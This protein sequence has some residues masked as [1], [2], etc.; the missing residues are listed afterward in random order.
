MSGTRF[1]ILLLG[2]GVA[3]GIVFYTLPPLFFFPLEP[4]SRR[5]VVV[6]VPKGSSTSEIASL[7]VRAG[8]IRSAFG[9][10]ALVAV[11]GS[12]GRLQAGE[13]ELSPSLTPWEIIRRLERGQVVRRSFT[14]PEG[15][16]AADVARRLARLGYGREED[17]LR[18]FSDLSLLNELLP[19]SGHPGAR[20]VRV[21]LEGYLYPDTYQFVGHPRPEEFAAMMLRRLRDVWRREL[22]GPAR[23]RRLDLHRLL[24][25]ASVVEREARVDAERP[26]IA[27]VFWNRLD[28]GMRLDA[29]P[30]VRYALG[31]FTG[32]LLYRDLTVDSPY[33]TYLHAGLP[34]GPIASPGLA[35]LRA[36]LAPADVPYLY[37]VAQPDGRHR[38]AVTL[39][40]HNRNVARAAAAWRAAAG[41]SAR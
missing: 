32:E 10:R 1:I 35:S 6:E 25:L 31:R 28:R 4:A 7:L 24:T 30:T 14:A 29:D 12:G 27:A 33:N 34:P 19:A 13:Y 3:L 37:F 40:E 23:A 15:A 9:F 16:T 17:F 22:E 8:V 26:V 20:A 36:V 21:A 11:R 5:V 39:A 18:A 41:S 2:I 38:F